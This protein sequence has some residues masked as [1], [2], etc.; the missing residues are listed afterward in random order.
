MHE[1][2]HKYNGAIRCNKKNLKMCNISDKKIK[3]ISL[4][5]F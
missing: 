3:Y 4:L 1:A 2:K 5:N